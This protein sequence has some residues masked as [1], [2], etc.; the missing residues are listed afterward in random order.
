MEKN[1]ILQL[2]RRGRLRDL[3][4]LLDTKL[5]STGGGQSLKRELKRHA[6]ENEQF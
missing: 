2:Q 6:L 4:Q 3:G 5:T 1:R